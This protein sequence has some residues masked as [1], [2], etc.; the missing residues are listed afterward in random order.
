MP[1]VKELGR[2][3]V[4]ANVAVRSL[5]GPKLFALSVVV[6]VPVPD[7]TSRAAISVTTGKAKYDATKKAIVRLWVLDLGL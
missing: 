2:T 6:L 1:A 7:N 3:R 4:E 5:F